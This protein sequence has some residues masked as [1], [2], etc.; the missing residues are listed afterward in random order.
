[1]VGTR[2]S[3]RT[4]GLGC[5]PRGGLPRLVPR[6][7]C[8]RPRQDSGTPRLSE[9][10]D[11]L[12]AA[13]RGRRR[14]RPPSPLSYRVLTDRGCT[15]TL[16]VQGLQHTLCVVV[17]DGSGS[18]GSGDDE[19]GDGD[20]SGSLGGWQMPDEPPE[21]VRIEAKILCTGPDGQP[22]EQAINAQSS[23]SSSSSSDHAVFHVT[24]LHSGAA[25]LHVTCDGRAVC[26]SPLHVTVKPAN[27]VWNQLSNCPAEGPAD[28]YT[29]IYGEINQTGVLK[30]LDWWKEHGSLGVGSVL[31]E[32]GA[33]RGKPCFVAKLQHGVGTVLGVEVVPGAQAP[34]LPSTSSVY[35]RGPVDCK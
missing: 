21:G 26:G 27:W 35:P 25:Q 33:G 15:P 24:P 22:F 20:S 16:L 18:A 8:R 19:D 28:R 4:D 13:K 10:D 32:A 30:I 6:L 31:L 23:S 11:G 12:S 14:P 17:D 9:H 7:S 29:P 2:T 34:G 5:G 3:S 1:M